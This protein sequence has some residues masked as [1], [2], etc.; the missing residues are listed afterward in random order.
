MQMYFHATTFVPQ[1]ARAC[2]LKPSQLVSIRDQFG[3]CKI[4][5]FYNVIMLTEMEK[6]IMKMIQSQQDKL[7]SDADMSIS[8]HNLHNLHFDLQQLSC[9]DFSN[10][11]SL[12]SQQYCSKWV[13]TSR[14]QYQNMSYVTL[15]NLII[16]CQQQ[17]LALIFIAVP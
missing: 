12:L 7:D 13:E 16:F 11:I 4:Q 8:S 5:Q 17:N 6:V 15:I 14:N 10:I 9:A 1:K 2:S 3:Q